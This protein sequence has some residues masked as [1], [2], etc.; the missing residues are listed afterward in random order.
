MQTHS[1][2]VIGRSQFDSSLEGPEPGKGSAEVKRPSLD[3]LELMQE[4]L[5]IMISVPAPSTAVGRLTFARDEH[6][7]RADRN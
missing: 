4:A 2:E 5:E 3:Q 6:N 7:R 1:A